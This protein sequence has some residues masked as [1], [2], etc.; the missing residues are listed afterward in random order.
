MPEWDPVKQGQHNNMKTISMKWTGIR[1][2]V[3]H[4]GLMADPT[5]PYTIAIKKITAKGSKKLTEHDYAERDRLE[6]E[7]GLYWSEELGGIAIPSDN[8]ERALQNG[9]MKSRL[10]KDFA[11]AVFVT[12][13][14]LAVAH[15]LAGKSKEKLYADPG[16]ILRKGVKV[17]TARIIRIRPML[18]TGWSITFTVEYD[19][20]IVNAKAIVQA[21]TDAGALVGLG[22]W[23]P[24]FGR[25]EAEVLS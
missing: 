7:A 19:E 1:P 2:L 15:K 25:F 21:A 20:S 18:P 10:G 3:M 6:W 22:D 9:A 13:P 14:D 11:A 5:N 24:K 23:R 17:Q 12:E 4:N 16:Y 8:I